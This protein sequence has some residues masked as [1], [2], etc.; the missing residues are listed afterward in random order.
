MGHFVFSFCLLE[1]Y[2][3]LLE[4]I[5]SFA[6][7][8]HLK[9]SSLVLP[10]CS[11]HWSLKERKVWS[12]TEARLKPVINSYITVQGHVRWRKLRSFTNSSS[13]GEKF[14]FGFLL[15]VFNSALNKVS[16]SKNSF[17]FFPYLYRVTGGFWCEILW[18][19]C[20]YWY[21]SLLFPE[22]CWIFYQRDKTK[23][24]SR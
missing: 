14:S 16:F 4:S 18:W 2:G 6:V 5:F 22:D 9:R 10:F 19:S 17:S 24:L 7:C 13:K 3:L 1:L 21:L 15:I 8:C 11:A 12:S 23:F 20:C